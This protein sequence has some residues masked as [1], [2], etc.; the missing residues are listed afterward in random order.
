MKKYFNDLTFTYSLTRFYKDSD[1]TCFDGASWLIK[2][3]S[4]IKFYL[5]FI[6]TYFFE[7]FIYSIRKPITF[8][9]GV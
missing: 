1:R 3:K 9:I 8:Y 2:Y 7:K 5:C 6:L 4:E